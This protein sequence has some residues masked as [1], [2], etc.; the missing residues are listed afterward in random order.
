MTERSVTHA[1]FVLERAFAAAPARVFAAFADPAL[2]A[3][4]FASP[5][6]WVSQGDAFDFR[7]GGH[8]WNAGGPPGGFVSRFDAHYYDIVPD[9]RIVYA[10][11]MHLDD[12]RISVSLATVDLVPDGSGTRMTLTEQSAY[13]AE[14]GA[15]LAGPE[16]ATMREMGTGMLLDALAGV[17][18]GAPEAA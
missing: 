14:A 5:P 17:V 18:D 16:G 8:E 6:G 2:K 10:Y 12:R 13:F 1:T 4:W 9:T 11:D 15:G 3:R 7:V